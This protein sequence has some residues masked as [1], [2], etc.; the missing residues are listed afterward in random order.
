MQAGE[1]L[2]RQHRD[3]DAGI[4]AVAHGRGDVEALARSLR[5]LRRHL[6]LEEQILFPL[7][8]NSGLT[9]PVF[10]MKRDHGQMWPLLERL[11]TSCDASAAL[12]TLQDGCREL[13][14]LLQMHNPKEEAV[15][16]TSA[17]Q[18]SAD[19]LVQ[20]LEGA[21]LPDGWRCELAK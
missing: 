11:T 17:D 19:T 13:L 2:K 10:V 20:D 16:Y 5:V 3:I 9:M 1:L 12:A 6:Y 8:V 15:I 21:E 4:E 18:I 7:L 14:Q